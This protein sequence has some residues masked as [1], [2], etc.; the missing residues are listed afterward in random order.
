MFLLGASS[1][2]W[3]LWSLISVM[4]CANNEGI[5]KKVVQRWLTNIDFHTL[6]VMVVF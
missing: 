3:D 4:K 6:K 1:V 5:L 2:Q